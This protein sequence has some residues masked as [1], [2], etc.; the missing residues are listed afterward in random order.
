MSAPTDLSLMNDII[1]PLKEAQPLLYIIGVALLMLL[2]WLRAGSAHFLLQR[3]WWLIAGSKRFNND[4][5]NEHWKA[6]RDVEGMRFLTRI[7]FPNTRAANRALALIEQHDIALNDLTRA[8]HFFDPETTRMKEPGLASRKR[9]AVA[10]LVLV[11][12]VLM[13][14]SYLFGQDKALLAVKKSGTNFWT[15][16]QTAE[17]LLG[18]SWQLTAEHCKSGPPVLAPEDNQVIC[19]ILTDPPQEHLQRL[20]RSQRIFGG[21]VSLLLILGICVICQR[22]ATAQL[23]DKLYRKL[24][25]PIPCTCQA[26]ANG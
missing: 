21:S 24:N 7:R 8:R 22:L 5:L 17:P 16:G 6:L 12:I 23:A 13:P 9:S 14:A 1:A 4:E 2:A 10:V 20:V 11:M 19:E 3:I 15:N 18:N 25:P 26:S